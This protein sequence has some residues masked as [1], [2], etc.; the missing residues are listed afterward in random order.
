MGRPRQL[1][2]Y[3]VVAVARVATTV[4]ADRVSVRSERRE[5]SVGMEVVLEESVNADVPA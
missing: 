4:R 2:A 5:R 3:A 1:W